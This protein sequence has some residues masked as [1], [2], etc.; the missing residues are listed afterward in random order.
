MDFIRDNCIESIEYFTSR[1]TI[2]TT[3]NQQSI[4]TQITC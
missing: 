3:V 4:V 1:F 2:E